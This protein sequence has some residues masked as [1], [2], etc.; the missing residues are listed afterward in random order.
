MKIK[1][2]RNFKKS[3]RKLR[4]SEKAQFRDRFTI[5]MKD[6]FNKLLNNHKLQGKYLDRR[7]INI[8][9]DLRALY[10]TP[11]SDIILFV[12]IDTHSNLYE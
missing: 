10:K 8:N 11:F 3:L 1:F 12:L 6:P 2:H 5:F 7:S 9:G 4:E